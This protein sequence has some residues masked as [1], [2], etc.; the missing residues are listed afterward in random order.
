MLTGRDEGSLTLLVIGYTFLAA[1]LVVVGIDV[2]KV[3]LAQRALASAADAAALSAAQELDR[4]A[5]YAGAETCGSLPLD[6]QA[7]AQAA[8]HSV[9]DA[10][11]GL[12]ATFAA[13]APPDVGVTAGTVTVRLHGEV[14][15]PFGR[16]V[17]LL[18]PGSPG[19]RVP[20]SA[21]A[22]AQSATTASV[23]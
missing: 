12:R 4:A 14:P 3:F 13:L 16:V 7:A 10:A 17:A 22:S 19:G 5:V 23:C 11:D 21:S 9:V 2:S 6:G 15:V 18:L 1:S 20:V 8:E